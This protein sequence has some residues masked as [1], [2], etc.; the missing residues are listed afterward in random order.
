[1]L[2][3]DSHVIDTDPTHYLLGAILESWGQVNSPTQHSIIPSPDPEFKS[4]MARQDRLYIRGEL[5][6]PIFLAFFPD[7]GSFL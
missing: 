2:I 3:L 4:A 7:Q 6:S 5:E 1:M